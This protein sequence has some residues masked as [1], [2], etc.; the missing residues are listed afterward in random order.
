M[1]RPA[2]RLPAGTCRGSKSADQG[3]GTV[4]SIPGTGFE[5]RLAEAMAHARRAGKLTVDEIDVLLAGPAFDA[6]RFADFVESAR[7]EGLEIEGVDLVP[8]GDDPAPQLV[9]APR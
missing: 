8:L 9:L 5:A 3:E 1:I 7:A 6:A 2:G 4:Q